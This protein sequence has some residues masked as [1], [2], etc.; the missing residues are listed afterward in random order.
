MEQTTLAANSIHNNKFKEYLTL[1]DIV[2]Q[3]FE[4][5]NTIINENGNDDIVWIIL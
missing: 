1:K 3:W 5:L 2:P 4:R